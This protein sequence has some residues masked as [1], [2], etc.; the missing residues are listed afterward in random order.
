METAHQPAIWMQVLIGIGAVAAILAVSW[1]IASASVNRK[2][3]RYRLAEAEGVKIRNQILATRQEFKD[4]YMPLALR[5]LLEEAWGNYSSVSQ[6]SH[7]VEN[8]AALKA[9]IEEVKAVVDRIKEQALVS[10]TAADFDADRL[11]LTQELSEIE[12]ATAEELAELEAEHRSNVDSI[13]SQLADERARIT[14]A[15]EVLKL[16]EATLTR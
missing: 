8:D 15:L 3:K 6:R 13:N 4:K 14:A 9:V 5:Q 11:A 12:T 10:P 7:Y 16:K 1:W 2:W